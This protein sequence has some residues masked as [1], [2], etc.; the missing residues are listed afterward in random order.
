MIKTKLIYDGGYRGEELDTKIN[1][2][3]E[4]EKIEKIID[5]KVFVR[6]NGII[7]ALVIYEK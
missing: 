3:I 5:V 2:F 7:N 1:E 6:L 4:K